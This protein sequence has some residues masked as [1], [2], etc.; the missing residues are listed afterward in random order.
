MRSKMPVIKS[1]CS[2]DGGGGIGGSGVAD[3]PGKRQRR[4]R[5]TTVFLY[6]GQKCTT[7]Y[8]TFNA[9][10]FCRRRVVFFF[11]SSTP[12]PPRRVFE[13]S[14]SI[15]QL[16]HITAKR[17]RRAPKTRLCQTVTPRDNAIRGHKGTQR[18]RH[19]KCFR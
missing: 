14:Y 16:L 11:L 8:G 5:P 17:S 4:T 2:G 15:S 19:S 13:E 10:P 9:K 6:T 7:T 3:S 18:L 1:S 12:V